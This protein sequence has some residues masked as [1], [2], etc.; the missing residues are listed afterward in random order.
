MFLCCIMA[1]NKLEQN[2]ADSQ[3]EEQSSDGSEIPSNQDRDLILISL[4]AY[5]NVLNELSDECDIDFKRQV[6]EIAESLQELFTKIKPKSKVEKL[7]IAVRLISRGRSLKNT[8]ES[9]FFSRAEIKTILI[10]EKNIEVW[11][12]LLAIVKLMRN[13]MDFIKND[14]IKGNKKAISLLDE[15]K[16]FNN[17]DAIIETTNN[18]IIEYLESIVV[19]SQTETTSIDSQISPELAYTAPRSTVSGFFR[20]PLIWIENR[21]IDNRVK[22]FQAL[23]NDFKNHNDEEVFLREFKTL[24][25]EKEIQ[26][27][28][29]KL[30]NYSAYKDA[31]ILNSLIANKNVILHIE[32]ECTENVIEELQNINN[33]NLEEFSTFIISANNKIK[34]LYNLFEAGRKALS[35]TSLV[36][37]FNSENLAVDYYS[38]LLQIKNNINFEDMSSI[39][40]Y[41]N[42]I[43]TNKLL[44]EE[45]IGMSHEPI[46]EKIFEIDSA[47]I[48]LFE[49]FFHPSEGLSQNY[50]KNRE[51]NYSFQD[52]MNSMINAVFATIGHIFAF[53]YIKRPQFLNQLGLSAFKALVK[54]P[55]DPG[56]ILELRELINKGKKDFP[57]RRTDKDSLRGLLL[58][59]E[60]RLNNLEQ[61]IIQDTTS[62][63][64]ESL[65]DD[66][67]DTSPLILRQF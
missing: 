40:A 44:G 63:T 31:F 59:F 48:E 38:N 14:I 20:N 52:Y 35:D 28:A 64:F 39:F 46:I 12:I 32:K 55:N 27:L 45:I 9:I 23:L 25:E 17:L 56:S 41:I 18:A 29:G 4:N 37:E 66:L 58:K 7:Q 54:N 53:D 43:K 42:N 30:N 2:P 34:D 10:N 24:L 36:V 3:S 8:L 67:S 51:E 26:K 60:D 62:Q 16:V 57:S 5:L 33:F 47:K 21:T 15:S 22:Q 65:E 11:K 19:E 1:T 13:N 61:N 49:T 50:L 6:I